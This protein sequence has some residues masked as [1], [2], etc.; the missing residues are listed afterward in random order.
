MSNLLAEERSLQR[1]W[2]MRTV[3]FIISVLSV[4][5]IA[6]NGCSPAAPPTAPEKVLTD[7]GRSLNEDKWERVKGRVS[8]LDPDQSRSFS[9]TFKIQT[10]KT[11]VDK[12]VKEIEA[13]R[14]KRKTIVEKTPESDPFPKSE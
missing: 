9:I 10:T 6:A 8:K 3:V 14:A 13:L 5:F 1:H 4:A 2:P 12:V 11:E 7:S